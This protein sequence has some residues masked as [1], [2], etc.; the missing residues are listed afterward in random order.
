MKKKAVHIVI[1]LIIV[2]TLFFAIQRLVVPKYADKPLEGNFT[3]EYYKETSD[4]EVMLI[5][6]C[7]V[8]ENINPI[9]MWQ[10][11]GITSYIRGNAQQ[12][13]WQSYYM[14]EDALKYET[15]KVV[16][17]NIQA[18]THG[19]PQREEYNR[20]TLDGMKWSKTKYNAIR[21]SMC[22]GENMLDYFLPLFRY[23]S[24]IL[25]VSENDVKYYWKSKPV[26]HNGYYMRVDVLP[27]SESDVADSSW[28]LGDQ[29]D[30]EEDVVDPWADIENADDDLDQSPTIGDSATGKGEKFGKYPMEYL[31]K[32]RKLCQKKGIKLVLMKAPSLSPEW[33]DSD[34]QQVVEYAEKYKLP[35]INFYE[36]IDTLK[37][38]YETD[39]YDGGLHMNLN[40]ADKLSDYLGQWLMEKYPLTDYRTDK[41]M[42]QIYD[43]KVRI[44]ENMKKEQENE[45]KK[46]GK[47][48]SY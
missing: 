42:S 40:G 24:R 46:Y 26:T 6:D 15:P 12:L 5:G 8:Y 18:L 19:E 22:R 16:V 43:K 32:M 33:Y 45:I 25:D 9:E 34:N 39:T 29:S 44:F 28:L 37:I 17:Y 36:L 47:V 20:M 23:H 13:T 14:L 41:K 38:D 30:E 2:V 27:V 35:Y 4:H 11:Y 21:A 7:E 48:V 10:K 31:D 1:S 3:A